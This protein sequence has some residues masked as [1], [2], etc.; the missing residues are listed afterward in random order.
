MNLLPLKRNAEHLGLIENNSLGKRNRDGCLTQKS[1]T[2]IHV[3]I[4]GRA[5]LVMASV[6]LKPHVFTAIEIVEDLVDVSQVGKGPVMG[7]SK[8]FGHIFSARNINTAELSEEAQNWYSMLML[9]DEGNL[10]ARLEDI[11]VIALQDII[12]T[13]NNHKMKRA[14]KLGLDWMCAACHGR[15]AVEADK[16]IVNYYEAEV[17]CA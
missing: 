14:A 11:T 1:R 8:Y 10:E 16:C 7:D 9:S 12:K 5:W 4:K 13:S 6:L 17:A 3:Q 15:W 2:N